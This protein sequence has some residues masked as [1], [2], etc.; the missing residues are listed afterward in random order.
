[1]VEKAS[2]GGG[3]PFVVVKETEMA[4]KTE[5]KARDKKTASISLEIKK[6]LFM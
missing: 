4:Q 1:M 3:E 6:H 5:Q 2:K